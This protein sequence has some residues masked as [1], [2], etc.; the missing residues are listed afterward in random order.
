M[1]A[2]LEHMLTWLDCDFVCMYVCVCVSVIETGLDL[3]NLFM[4]V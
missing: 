2:I 3:L 4:K 1:D